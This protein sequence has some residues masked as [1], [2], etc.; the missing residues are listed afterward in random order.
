MNRRHSSQ[1]L[2]PA[3]VLPRWDAVVIRWALTPEERTSL[4]AG[5]L[6]GPVDLVETY[7]ADEA[8]RRMRLVIELAFALEHVFSSEG[9]TRRWLRR[10]HVALSDRTPIEAMSQSPEWTRTL[11]RFLGVAS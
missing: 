8:D 7:R 9:R 2:P 6:E 5:A 11:I 3:S 1:A 4:L 10:P